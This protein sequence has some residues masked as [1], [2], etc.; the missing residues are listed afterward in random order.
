MVKLVDRRVSWGD[1][2][3]YY[4]DYPRSTK[5][6][7]GQLTR[8]FLL[9]LVGSVLGTDKSVTMNLFYMPCLE[10]IDAIGKFNWRGG[11]GLASMYKNMG[12]ALSRGRKTTGCLWRLWE[13]SAKA[14]YTS[15]IANML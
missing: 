3:E 1:L 5:Q 12:D 9:A 2:Y 10:H 13:V 11:A 7:V 15:F 6:E 4:V 14:S 8:V